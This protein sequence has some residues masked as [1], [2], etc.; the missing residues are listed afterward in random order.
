MEKVLSVDEV[1][2]ADWEVEC[3]SSDVAW[4]AAYSK[5]QMLQSV[6]ALVN[7]LITE[8]ARN[9]DHEKIGFAL[10]LVKTWISG[11]L[12]TMC[13]I[14]YDKG[15]LLT[16]CKRVQRHIKARD[17]PAHI[18]EHTMKTLIDEVDNFLNNDLSEIVTIRKELERHREM[19][20]YR[21][22]R[23]RFNEDFCRITAEHG[24]LLGKK[25]PLVEIC[26]NGRGGAAL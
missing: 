1:K 11:V 2:K 14:T 26:S 15:S 8:T 13:E 9:E 25:D 17:L 12:E 3:S 20:T 5:L 24:K 23:E 22:E 10:D 21:K 18:L 16:K 6:F 19:V 7:D 4:N